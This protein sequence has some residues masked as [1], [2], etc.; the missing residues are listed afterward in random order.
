MAKK[1]SH[2]QRKI[3]DLKGRML[4]FLIGFVICTGIGSI[5]RGPVEA[6]AYESH[7]TLIWIFRDI[8]T[9]CYEGVGQFLGRAVGLPIAGK[10]GSVFTLL[11]SLFFF[12]I[13]ASLYGA[14]SGEAIADFGEEPETGFARTI[15]FIASYPYLATVTFIMMDNRFG[16]MGR[17][18]RFYY[19]VILLLFLIAPLA[20][21][22]NH[23]DD[24]RPVKQKYTA[25]WL[26]SFG[27][28][29]SAAGFGRLIM[30]SG[31]ADKLHGPA[32]AWPLIASMAE[33]VP[34]SPVGIGH[35]LLL[36]AIPAAILAICASILL[37]DKNCSIPFSIV[38]FTLLVGGG[39]IFYAF[40]GTNGAEPRS[41]ATW[42]LLLF[43]V[44]IWTIAAPRKKP[45]VFAA[46]I[47]LLFSGSA[48]AVGIRLL[49]GPFFAAIDTLRPMLQPLQ[50]LAS[51]RVTQL[52]PNAVLGFLLALVI[53]ILLSTLLGLP[54]LLSKRMPKAFAFPLDRVKLFYLAS[55]VLLFME[56]EHEV[57]R[58]IAFFLLLLSLIC[59]AALLG[60]ALAFRK[61]RAILAILYTAGC[62]AL[63]T[64]PFALFAVQFAWI[65]CALLLAMNFFLTV[66]A[67]ME[68]GGVDSKDKNKQ[69]H[70]A[71]SS[72]LHDAAMSGDYSFHDLGLM[73]QSLNFTFGIDRSIWDG[74]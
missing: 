14:Y 54:V 5:L 38:S 59:L 10:A 47:L 31:I 69:A 36:L 63:L 49:R 61:L 4:I 73:Q 28:A 15:H 30:D 58:N 6:P 9:F 55:V 71:A 62:M 51:D 60:A 2:A 44:I 20:S 53:C 35:V 1:R 65:F 32:A 25:R 41:I 67:A 19:T 26:A 43:A 42:I 57:F 66:K 23:S 37:N 74:F 11:S 64:V 70:N 68:A 56:S 29:L 17:N 72:L 8:R 7:R 27:V 3:P 48:L 18:N 39:V 12:L 40:R 33:A 34:A 46:G 52:I 13:S 21:I 50:E 24:E 22:Y 45:L 16:G